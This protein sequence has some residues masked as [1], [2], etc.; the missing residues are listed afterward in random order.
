[1]IGIEVVRR[2]DDDRNLIIGDRLHDV[3]QFK[4]RQVFRADIEGLAVYSCIRL[5]E[6]EQVQVSHIVDVNVGAFLRTT[7]DSDAPLVDRVVGEGVD[8]E[9]ET[10]ARRIS[11]D[12]SGSDR[13]GDE[14]GRALLFEYLLA[15]RLVFCIVRERFQ[16]QFLGDFS[17][18]LD[19]VNTE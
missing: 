2:L 5:I 9:I 12:D 1:M 19:T 18:V 4:K 3:R 11:A 7:E 14:T 16:R 13:T 6:Q 17:L 10:L 15:K 8:D